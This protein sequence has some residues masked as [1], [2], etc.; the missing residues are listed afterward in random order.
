[1]LLLL[2][3]VAKIVQIKVLK[4]KTVLMNLSRIVVLPTQLNR[5]KSSQTNTS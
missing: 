3:L 5:G 2:G 1:M 4:K